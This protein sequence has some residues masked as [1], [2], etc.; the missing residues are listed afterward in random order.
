MWSYDLKVRNI[1][2]SIFRDRWVLSHI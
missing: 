2:I 1:L